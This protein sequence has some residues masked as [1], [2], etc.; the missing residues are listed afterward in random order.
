MALSLACSC[1]ARFEVEDTLAGQLVSCPECPKSVRA[2]WPD[3]TKLRT[4]GYALGSVILALVGAFTVVGTLAA[5]VLGATGL[6]SIARNRDRLTG[7]GYAVFGI[8]AGVLLTVF[9]LFL[10]TSFELFDV[11]GVLRSGVLS[12]QI[13]Y[14]GGPEINR[15]QQGYAISRPNSKWGVARDSLVKQFEL[16][17][18]LFLVNPSKDCYVEVLIVDMGES[19]MD[20]FLDEVI[21][22]YKE[23]QVQKVGARKR[24]QTL[25]DFKLRGRQILPP[26]A[27][28][29][30]AELLIDLKVDGQE[31]TF[32]DRIVREDG[33]DRAFR[34]RAW[35]S[36]RRFGRL[37]AELRRAL[38]SFRILP[39]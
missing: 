2:P 20:E 12:S 37:E 4:S 17:C 31:M 36:R 21:K 28:V 9:S 26:A 19:S 29:R 33:G 24:A 6:V 16:D 32:L 3:Q 11:N 14:G 38:D 13:D 7:V 34:V 1:G 25:S 35:A 18:D 5:V 10:Y 8:V 27:G 39:Q 30:S 15:K 22:A 23:D